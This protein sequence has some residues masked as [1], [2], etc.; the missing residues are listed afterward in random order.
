MTHASSKATI[1][2]PADVIWRVIS[3]FGTAC[4]YLDRVVHR[5]VEGEGFSG[6]TEG[7]YSSHTEW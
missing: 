6:P 3:D 1:Y 5:I 7:D 4:Q 2:V